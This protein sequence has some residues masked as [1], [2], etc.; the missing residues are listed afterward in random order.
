MQFHFGGAGGAGGQQFDAGSFSDF[1]ETLFGGMGGQAGG[2]GPGGARF[3]RTSDG[4]GDAFGGFSRG[5]RRGGDAQA[6]LDLTLEEAYKGGGKSIS[7]QEQA[8]GP[9]GAP[10]MKTKTLQIN[11]PA[12]V[13]D[14][15]KIRL[16]G[17]GNP[18]LG[19][20]A[21]GDLYLKIKIL[22]HR[23]FKLDGGDVVLDLPVAPW[24]AALGAKV[25]T[26]TLD[27]AVE[28]N[29]PPGVGSGKKLRIP[30]KGLGGKSKRADQLV[31]IMIQVPSNLTEKERELMEQL[32]TVSD[33]NPRTF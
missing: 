19:G 15:S 20:G 26:P 23:L 33:F 29:I 17:Q 1:F 21:A 32:S 5:A 14:G 6:T 9:D 11:V 27:G 31:R 12:G 18:G 3:R 16:A 4:F 8:L 13:R 24:E 25:R 22:P 2:T 30:G 28:L 10:A 7:L